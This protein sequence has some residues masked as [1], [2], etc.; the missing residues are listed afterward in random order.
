MAEQCSTDPRIRF[1]TKEESNARREQEFLAL[2][3]HERFMSFLRG[4]TVWKAMRSKVA[5]P[6]KGNFI[7]HRKAQEFGD[8]VRVF[9]RAVG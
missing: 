9:L 6:D 7:I 4:F 1:E 5:A 3:P 8:E 2:A